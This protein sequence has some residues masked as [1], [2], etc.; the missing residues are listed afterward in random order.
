[1]MSSTRELAEV[2]VRVGRQDREAFELLYKVTHRKLYGIILGILRNRSRADETLQEVYVKVWQ[3]AVDFDASKSSP[4]TWLAVIARNRA[5][6]ELRRSNAAPMDDVD[7][8]ID[9]QADVEHPLADM[10]RSDKFK[11]VLRCLNTLEPERRDLVLL[12]YYRGVSR[13]A[14]AVRFG[15]PTATIK[16][17]LH[18]SLTQLKTCLAS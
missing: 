10:E 2:M 4:I 17:W 1:M 3:R 9:L 14:L 13:D 16:T 6:D 18:R 15:R 5:L 8:H 12:A 7:D 11:S